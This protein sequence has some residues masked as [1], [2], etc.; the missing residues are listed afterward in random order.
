MRSSRAARS[1]TTAA[2]EVH[3]LHDV[4]GPARAAQTKLAT[5]V[6]NVPET[7]IRVVSPDVGGGF[8]MKAN[9]YPDDVLVLWASRRM[10]PSGEMDG[11][12]Q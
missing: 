3:A 8:G 2:S 11:D 5:A 1:D 7:K 12:A 9:I 6:F 4:A 10:R